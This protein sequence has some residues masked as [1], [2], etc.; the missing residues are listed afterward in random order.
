[1]STTQQTP[2]SVFIFG[3]GYVGT[4]VARHWLAAGLRVGALTR[5][6]AKA[7]HL[8]ELGVGEVIEGDLDSDRWHGAIQGRYDGVLNCVSS[9]G[10][11][12][13][14]Y[15][16]SYLEGQRSVLKWA[17]SQA[18]QCYL[19]TSSTSVYPQD[20]GSVV[21]ES[22]DT[23]G[24]PP[25]G[26]IV[27]ESEALLEAAPHL[28]RWYVLRLAGIYG[29][30]RHYLLDQLQSGEG[31]IPGSGDYA[32]NMIHLHDIVAAVDA[33]FHSDAPSGIYNI[34]DDAPATK[35]EVLAHLAEQLRLPAP[36]FNPAIVSERLRRR[37]GRM[38]H[39]FVSNA[40][41]KAAF[42]WTPKYPSY[43][44]GYAGLI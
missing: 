1:M 14:G 37:G 28:R 15:R 34:A 30:G 6:P 40:K 13:D 8:R 9:A 31:E 32:L 16:K 36:R 21:D 22:S 42:A 18:I 29:P 17:E 5:N 38:P 41:A 20:G 24:A 2:S 26:Q 3:C 11:G 27:R 25:T 33:A 35:A 19:Y 4:A 10:G 7:A 23:G 12:L 44:E 43:R 39:R